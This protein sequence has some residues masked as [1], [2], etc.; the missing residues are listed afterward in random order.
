MH[1]RAL[2]P[3]LVI[4]IF[5]GANERDRRRLMELR[6]TWGQEIS[7]P[8]NMDA[9]SLYHT[10][11]AAGR[12]TVDDRTWQDL[13]MDDLFARIDRN[14]G[15][16]GQQMLYHQMRTYETDDRTLAERARQQ[17]ALKDDP[18]LREKCQLLLSRLGASGGEWLGSMLLNP[19][20]PNPHFAPLLYLCSFLGAACILGIA[21]IHL[22]FLPALAM[23]F[24]N[25]AITAN[26]GRQIRPY[27]T[28]FS[29]I[30]T[31]LGV[32]EELAAIPNP[33]ALPQLD[34]LR[35]SRPLA[36]RL[37]NRLGWLVMDRTRMSDLSQLAVDYINMFFLFDI[38]VYL[39]SNAAL[40]QHKDELVGLWEAVGS[41][42][43][44]IAV[45]SYL[46]GVPGLIRPALGADRSLEVK[47]I[48]HPLLATPVGNSLNLDDRSALIAGPNMAGKTAFIRTLGINV[49]LAQ[50]LN[51]CLA[52]KAVLPRAVVRSAIRREDNL[53]A[54]Q[55]YFFAEIEQIL[56]FTR[57]EE[58]GPRCLFLIDEIFRGTNTVE[59]V[60]A[61][62][63]V[64]H[65]LGRRQLVL[66]TT[67]DVELQQLLADTF[68]M[69]HFSDQVL[70]G[71]Y[72]F[73][74]H[75]HPG[76]AQS[77]NAIRLLEISGYPASIIREAETLAARNSP[78]S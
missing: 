17:S 18:V 21:F 43:A 15:T 69:Y 13:G 48:C 42:D 37:R 39:R 10:S 33:H 50:T 55:S 61:S 76:P 4:S 9:I 57:A 73:D 6:E 34:T 62:T 64:L 1:L 52:E 8:R 36:A 49:I 30:V 65:H 68:D 14:A 26:Y 58:A 75:I 44:S 12:S 77:R 59:R 3:S 31:M 46:Q 67:H 56:E 23:M 78:R 35:K 72:G 7:R 2:I 16:P 19:F 47:G 45:A 54:G 71:R 29:Q 20:P 60:A 32:S 40:R 51:L 5:G 24:I 63:A 11:V 66:A 53:E 38:V 28:G 70:D 22:L 74:Y 41:L 27:F 25:I